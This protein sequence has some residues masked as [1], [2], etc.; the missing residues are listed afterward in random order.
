MVKITKSWFHKPWF[1]SKAISM[2]KARKN[3]AAGFTLTE[4]MVGL[5]VSSLVALATVT[6]FSQQSGVIVQQT[7]MAQSQ[8]DGRQAQEIVL[9]LLRQAH[10][11]SIVAGNV[12]G[13]H[14]ITFTLPVGVAI[15]P[16]DDSPFDRN[17]V[18]IVWD[19]TD[20]D[21][22]IG[23][24]T[25]TVADADL[26]AFAGNKQ[27][28]NTRITAFALTGTAAKRVLTLTAQAG[29]SKDTAT[30]FENIFIPRN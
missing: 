1:F 12:T 3:N 5:T 14:E 17:N 7:L 30:S 22:A 16:N 8:S 11:D 19:D 27:G 15:W 6:A 13:G 26:K 18:R 25:G 2:K 23:A 20:F 21:L 24:A 10:R 29:T 28:T 4:L 9:R